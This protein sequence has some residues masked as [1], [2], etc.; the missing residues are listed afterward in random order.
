[1]YEELLPLVIPLGVAALA[2]GLIG[3]EREMR[4]KSAGFRTMILISVGSCLFTLLSVKMGGP[5]NESTRIAASVVA[6]I[7][8]LGA[9]VIIKDGVS[10][11][12]LTTAASVW[13]ASSIGMAA[14]V[15]E[16]ELVGVVV[17]IALVVL[18][19]FPPIERLFEKFAEYA[20]IHVTIK[21]T[22]TAESAI[23]DI[24]DEH[25]AQIVKI[26]RSILV[27]GERVVH[28][29]TKIR[30]SKHKD[31]SEILVNKKGIIKIEY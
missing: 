31:L 22:N 23:L 27:K 13:V 8:F 19:A 30:P 15:K 26:R 5:D 9:G 10:I 18:W 11:R 7:G 28:I 4:S 29:T 1:M 6:G 2:G 16:Y 20:T 24:F 21:N 17:V 3:I 12:G 25:K 14:G